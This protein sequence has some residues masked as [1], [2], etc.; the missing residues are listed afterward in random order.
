M[1]A[2]TAVFGPPDATP[3]HRPPLT[4]GVLGSLTVHRDGHPIEIGQPML[5]ALL[6]LLALQPGQTVSREHIVDVL[7][8]ENPP[9]TCLKLL[10]GYVGQLRSILEPQRTPRAPAQVLSLVGNGYQLRLTGEQ[11][12]LAQ[13]ND[14]L[15]RARDARTGGDAETALRE[16]EQALACWRGPVLADA[17]PNL[18]QHPAA[19]AAAR[20]RTAAVLTYADTAIE[21]G[22]PDPACER[23]QELLAEEPLHEALAA[24]LMRALAASGQRAA[25]LD[26]F[27]A[28]RARLADELGIEPDAALHEAY[29]DILRARPAEAERP[30]A[31][32]VPAQLPLDVPGFSGRGR[33]LRWLDAGLADAGDPPRSLVVAALTGTPGCGKTAV[34]VHWAHR[35]AHRFPDGQLYLDLRGFDPGGPAMVP[36]EAAR[37]LLEA[38]DVP[39]DGIPVSPQA[40]LGLYRSL[41]AGRR[42]LILLDNAR[43]AEQVRP[44]LPGSPGCAVLVTSRDQLRGLLATSNARLLT[45][46]LPSPHDARRL[47]AARIGAQRTAAEPAAVE[48]IIARCARLPLALAIV[49]ARAATRP[50]LALSAITHELATRNLDGLSGPDAATDARAAFSWSY[51]TLSPAAATAF[52]LIG[53]T[54]TGSV[55][56][57]VTASLTGAA[58]PAAHRVLEELTD[59]NL[60]TEST[61]GRYHLHSLLRAYAA[62]LSRALDATTARRQ[63]LHRLLDHHLATART[64]ATLLEPAREQ[65]TTAPATPGVTPPPLATREQALAWFAAERGTLLAAIRRAE[66]GG[67][68][69]HCWQLAHSVSTFLYARGHWH[70]LVAAQRSAVRAARRLGERTGEG[71]THLNLARAYSAL[72]RGARMRPHLR[73]ALALFTRSGDHGGLARAHNAI[74]LSHSRQGEHG[75]ALHHNQQALTHYRL[76]GNANGYGQALNDIGW[77]YAMLGRHRLALRYCRRALAVL[78]GL[79][80]PTEAAHTWDSLGY[81]HHRLGDH[82]RAVACYERAVALFREN[83]SR[84]HEAESLTR[85]GDTHRAAGD[86]AAARA[87]WQQARDILDG[88]RHADTA[89]VRG[90]L[91][92]LSTR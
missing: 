33:E 36:A 43:D 78:G 31:P 28:T 1:R 73:R 53:H 55:T 30:R 38:L 10:Q 23:L 87:A 47:L 17:P 6:G 4:V 18:R 44:L 26:L 84:Y 85:L 29:L 59:A 71:H 91:A 46:D 57:D 41:L 81:V 76:A 62:E 72:G 92:E 45:L 8:P 90:L 83:G 39:P 25:A 65:L 80:D 24:R 89:R 42:V 82:A 37:S 52:R 35:V 61:P 63:A 9:P 48:E 60:V 74:A 77:G 11:L 70:D 66:A 21:R 58:T 32:A 34:A 12:D 69:S 68:D 49:G 75:R 64:A 86:G 13:F 88:L 22:R 50:R 56:A 2:L 20:R 67:W 16:L 15:A 27:A 14:R 7:W 51:R 19:A 79:A 54:A 3:A 40:Q 5:R